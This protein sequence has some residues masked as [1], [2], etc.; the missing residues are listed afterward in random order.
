MKKLFLIFALASIVTTLVLRNLPKP[1][2][3]TFPPP[4]V[5][6][7]P[8]SQKAEDRYSLIM[9]ILDADGGKLSGLWELYQDDYKLRPLL[10]ESWARLGPE[11]YKKLSLTSDDDEL[12]WASAVKHQGE[13]ILDHTKDFPSLDAIA[14]AHLGLQSPQRAI[15]ILKSN[16]QR[17]Y[18]YTPFAIKDGIL[19]GLAKQD[20]KG[21]ADYY[22]DECSLENEF[23]F[24]GIIRDWVV[25]DPEQAIK[26]VAMN[27]AFDH[28]YDFEDFIAYASFEHSKLM[29]TLAENLPR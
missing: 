17:F 14:L 28:S 27:D 22:L 20:P 1:S 25:T 19:I 6:V 11:N 8:T 5:E 2:L 16:P 10:I 12:F 18:K 15:E 26:W 7:I 4:V 21:A 13:I 9:S 3:P 23:F 24:H 29:A